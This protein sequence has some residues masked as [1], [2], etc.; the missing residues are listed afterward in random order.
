MTTRLIAEI[1]ALRA[2][3]KTLTEERDNACILVDMLGKTYREHLN[4]LR[5][6]NVALA[7]RVAAQSELLGKKAE[8]TK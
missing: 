5:A 8:G 4:E 6:M 3:V 7:E 2:Q 1:T